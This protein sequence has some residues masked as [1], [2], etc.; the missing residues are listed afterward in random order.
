[1]TRVTFACGACTTGGRVVAGSGRRPALSGSC[2][3]RPLL[4]A[5]GSTLCCSCSEVRRVERGMAA[6][7][8]ER[9][10]CCSRAP[11]S[12]YNDGPL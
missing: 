2:G 1:M 12:T 8:G 6:P 9:R 7:R 5:R 10:P 11:Y 3:K 4:A